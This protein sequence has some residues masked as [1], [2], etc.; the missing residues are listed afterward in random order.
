MD[1]KSI[2]DDEQS[3]INY[4]TLESHHGMDLTREGLNA[5]GKKR[6]ATST[7]TTDYVIRALEE[8][9]DEAV[10]SG[11]SS[12]LEQVKVTE[13]N[14]VRNEM[15]R[16]DKERMDG[17]EVKREYTESKAFWN[18]LDDIG[19]L[20]L[21]LDTRRG[22]LRDA[23]QLEREC[24]QINGQLAHFTPRDN[25]QDRE[26]LINDIHEKAVEARQIKG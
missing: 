1:Q 21:A 5:T 6:L 15:A 22:N 12:A 24:A 14:K 16:V 7:G 10:L 11:I 18:L 25:D 17:N 19:G 8:S 9:A 26:D 20:K 3:E 4:H 23:N 2:P 13:L